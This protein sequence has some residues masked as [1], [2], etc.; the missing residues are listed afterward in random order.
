MTERRPSFRRSR[1]VTG[2]NGVDG[3]STLKVSI[4]KPETA[5]VR[6]QSRA[7]PFPWVSRHQMPVGGSVDRADLLVDCDLGAVHLPCDESARCR[8]F[9]QQV[10]LVIAVEVM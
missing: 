3:V 4:G 10:G 9:K 7:R 8:I 2:S 5:A 6:R 1:P